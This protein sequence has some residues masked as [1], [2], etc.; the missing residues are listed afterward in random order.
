MSDVAEPRPDVALADHEAIVALSAEIAADLVVVGP[1]GP[2]VEGLADELAA[3][4]SAVFGPSARAAAIE[5]SKAF[6]R[7]V[8]AAAGVPMAEGAVFD[9]IAPAF[10]YARSLGGP[11]VV[12]A[13]G[14]AAG[15]GV[16]VCADLVAVER[17][18]VEALTLRVFGAAGA[19]VVVERA[20]AGAE[21]SVIAIC[22]T[23]TAFALPAAR[24]YKRIGDGDRGPNTGGMGA[25]SPL[26]DL[27]LEEAATLLDRFHRPVLRELASRGAPFRG[28]LYAG[29]ILTDAG[30]RL[31]EFNAR[32]GDPEAQAILPRLGVPLGT[33]LLAAA[34]DR[35]AEAADS[36]A[37]PGAVRSCAEA[38]ACVVLASAGYPGPPEAGDPIEGIDLARTS[39]ALVFAAGV[40]S[41]P[42]R[43]GGLRTAGGRV[44]SL[45]GRGATVED[46]AE[47]A[48]EAAGRI[49]FRG[50]QLRHDIGRPVADA[51]TP[52]RELIAIGR[53]SA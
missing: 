8:A 12:K 52:T 46:A 4:G 41:D 44:L 19:R 30:P 9:S 35:L 45:V 10:E 49:N 27:S 34:T 33:L 20:L 29:L 24:D 17:A 6:C 26:P 23:T 47:Q 50:M 25:Y 40:A 16:T 38:S 31:L 53:G 15:K 28:A 11:V 22:D 32:F 51:A 7:E 13:D 2:L 18:L 21:A 48:Y 14:L 42:A 3:E 5:G 1:E 39:G 37:L 36:L 43:L